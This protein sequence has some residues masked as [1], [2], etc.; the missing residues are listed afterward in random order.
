MTTILV[1]MLIV[2]SAGGYN[3]GTVTVVGQFPD[4]AECYKV[5]GAIP[6]KDQVKSI[7]VQAKILVKE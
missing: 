7:C 2:T 4:A 3:H 6:N 5:Q 1:W